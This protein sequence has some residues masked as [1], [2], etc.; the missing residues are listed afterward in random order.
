MN[1]QNQY[2]DRQVVTGRWEAKTLKLFIEILTKYSQILQPHSLDG[3]EKIKKE[4]KRV[5]HYVS[6]IQSSLDRSEAD[7]D[8]EELVMA[9]EEYGLLLDLLFKEKSSLNQ[10]YRE[11]KERVFIDGALEGLESKIQKITDILNTD[12][13]QRAPRKKALVQT[14]RFSNE[15]KNNPDSVQYSQTIIGNVFGSAVVSNTGTIKVEMK[16]E[17]SQAYELLKELTDLVRE[18][19]LES[20]QKNDIYL[21]IQTLQSQLSKQKPNKGIMTGALNSLEALGNVAQISDFFITHIAPKIALLS[22]LIGQI[23]G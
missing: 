13:M 7:W 12:V 18:L 21:D 17:V 16:Q 4:L 2:D 11:K 22:T 23:A 9:G 20:T 5:S 15:P 10:E 6:H 1:D 8:L 19:S 14:L 3:N